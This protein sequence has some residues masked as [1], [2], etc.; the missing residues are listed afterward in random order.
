MTHPYKTQSKCRL[1]IKISGMTPFV[2]QLNKG[3]QLHHYRQIVD[4]Y[5]TQELYSGNP[6]SPLYIFK[7]VNFPNGDKLFEYKR[8]QTTNA[9]FSIEMQ[10]QTNINQEP[11]PCE[12]SIT[13]VK[14]TFADQC[15]L[16]EIPK[17]ISLNRLLLLLTDPNGDPFFERV[18]WYTHRKLAKPIVIL[19]KLLER[20]DLKDIAMDDPNYTILEK[21]YYNMSLKRSVQRKVLS[22]ISNWIDI[23]FFD[24]DDKM[25][26]VLS[27]FCYN[28]LAN[29]Q[30]YESIAEV[31]IEKMS[32][33]SREEP[34]RSALPLKSIFNIPSNRACTINDTAS[35]SSAT[36]STTGSLSL[37]STTAFSLIYLSEQEIAELLTFIDYHIYCQIHFSEMLGQAWNKDDKRQTAP[38]IILSTNFFNLVGNWVA[39][40]LLNIHD[41]R[42]RRKQL[43]RFIHITNVLYEMNSLNMVMAVSGGLTNTSVHRL[44]NT[45]DSLDDKT[46][47]LWEKMIS[48]VS[49]TQNSKALRLRMKELYD[50][51]KPCCP[52][53][54]VYL[55]DLVF[56]DDGNPTFIDGKIHFTKCAQQYNMMHQVL[57]FQN[58]EYN[59]SII[60]E[61]CMDHVADLLSHEIIDD[62]V[63]YRMS[64]DVQPRKSG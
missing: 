49:H 17:L 20:F 31:L 39:V 5:Y 52:F 16:S 35:S 38:N 53:A 23:S 46:Q 64:L 2:L 40:T 24:W 15:S 56:V 44:T 18:F 19:T 22:V 60:N 3:L 7:I 32:E 48:L 37:S 30:E 57:R 10:Q 54:G 61:P 6:P 50:T 43:K 63:L 21:H 26:S 55:K 42:E 41:I 4:L 58:R 36:P 25:V 62:K 59:T 45:W 29:S 1:F 13:F 47:K 14:N 11:P 27:E 9:I 28:T 8:K 33:N 51:G 34:W 12:D